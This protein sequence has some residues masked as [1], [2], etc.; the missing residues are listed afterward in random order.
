MLHVTGR[1]GYLIWLGVDPD[2]QRFGVGKRLFHA[3]KDL[4]V[5]GVYTLSIKLKNKTHDHTA[6][7]PFL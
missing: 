4:M 3:F 5:G 7:R 1:Y 6:Y 2:Y